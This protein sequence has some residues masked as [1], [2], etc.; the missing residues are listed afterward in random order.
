MNRIDITNCLEQYSAV[1]TGLKAYYERYR[2]PATDDLM[3]R[4]LR[5]QSDRSSDADERFQNVDALIDND[6]LIATD[7]EGRSQFSD[8]LWFRQNIDVS[9]RKHPRYLPLF[10][11]THSFIEMAYVYRGCSITSP[12]L[13][14]ASSLIYSYTPAR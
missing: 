7:A 5:E 9:V 10:K 2:H 13:T 1:E 6:S 3:F 4:L 12:S 14:T 8:H 11:H